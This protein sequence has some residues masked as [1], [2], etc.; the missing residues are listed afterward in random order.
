MARCLILVVKAVT[1][2][3]QRS[4]SVNSIYVKHVQSLRENPD[5]LYQKQKITIQ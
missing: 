5:F 3:Q 2:V 4:N 1:S